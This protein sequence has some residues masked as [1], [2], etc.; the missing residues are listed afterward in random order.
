LFEIGR[1]YQQ[2]AGGDTGTAE[3]RWASIAVTGARG[4]GSWHA[5]AERVDDYDVKGLAE[6][7]LA[8]LGVAVATR[9]GGRLGGFEPDCHGSLVTAA[10]EV[11]GEFGELAADVRARFGL[12]APVFAAALRLDALPTARTFPRAQPLPRFPSVQRDMAFAIADAGLSVAAVQA[13]IG[14]AAGPL[15]REVAVFDVFRLPDGARSVA[16]RLT[17]QAED[18]TLTDDEVNAIHAQVAGQVSRE[19]GITLRGS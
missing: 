4:D 8:A 6:H 13:A 1:T 7:A 2:V 18:R 10:G 5:G 14:R 12:D 15:L 9:A 11:V 3:P 17:F 16:W 19:F